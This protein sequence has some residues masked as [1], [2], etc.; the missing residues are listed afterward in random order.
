MD[1]RQ[2]LMYCSW[3]WVT[4]VTR[5]EVRLLESPVST[6]ILHQACESESTALP[7]TRLREGSRYDVFSSIGLSLHRISLKTPSGVA[8]PVK[9]RPGAFQRWWDKRGSSILAS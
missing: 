3:L 4:I 6:A 5:T 2:G 9:C 7:A 1:S 8:Y